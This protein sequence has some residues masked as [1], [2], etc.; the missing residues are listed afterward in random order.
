MTIVLQYCGNVVI[1]IALVGV[2]VGL[3]VCLV[4]EGYR[5]CQTQNPNSKVGRVF[6]EGTIQ[7]SDKQFSWSILAS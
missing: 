3:D 4:L 1:V 2:N 6:G 7:P 5:N